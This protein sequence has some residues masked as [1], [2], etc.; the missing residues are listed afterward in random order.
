MKEKPCIECTIGAQTL[1]V[2]ELAM[3]G[4]EL[5]WKINILWIQWT[6]SCSFYTWQ[7]CFTIHRGAL[8]FLLKS[9]RKLTPKGPSVCSMYIRN[10]GKV[11]TNAFLVRCSWNLDTMCNYVHPFR[12]NLFLFSIKCPNQ[13]LCCPKF[14]RQL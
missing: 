4:L 6:H 9:C 1:K 10:L 7:N 8:G 5:G 11:S 13:N 14:C 3:R 12:E 2:V